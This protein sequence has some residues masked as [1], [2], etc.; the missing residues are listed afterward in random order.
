MKRGADQES[1][2]HW[3]YWG[4]GSQC[5]DETRADL[6]MCFPPQGPSALGGS[7]QLWEGTVFLAGAGTSNHRAQGVCKWWTQ[8]VPWLFLSCHRSPKVLLMLSS[9]YPH[10]WVLNHPLF[11]AQPSPQLLGP[12]QLVCL[13]LLLE[14]HPQGPPYGVQ[15]VHV[16]CRF[17]WH[18]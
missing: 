16:I 8:S 7:S 2:L 10:T 4:P 15:D 17:K 11:T 14:H 3:W 9:C 6:N 1:H 13:N 12:L 18:P 5:T